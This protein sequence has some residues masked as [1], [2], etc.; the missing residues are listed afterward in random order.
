MLPPS[1]AGHV[2]GQFHGHRP[3]PQPRPTTTTGELQL[4]E[5]EGERLAPWL[6]KRTP[7]HSFLPSFLHSRVRSGAAVHYTLSQ[8]CRCELRPSAQIWTRVPGWMQSST[9]VQAGWRVPRHPPSS[10]TEPRGQMGREK[11]AAGSRV[12]A[13]RSLC[14]QGWMHRREV[15]GR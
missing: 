11:G 12:R 13:I 7:P 1:S 15:L 5:Q 4:Q 3:S 9:A 2:E 14:S 10:S 8:W 6:S